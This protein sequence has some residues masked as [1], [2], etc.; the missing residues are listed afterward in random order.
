[1]YARTAGLCVL[2]SLGL[3]WAQDVGESA[4]GSLAPVIASIQ[5]SQGYPLSYAE[6]KG[7]SV[8]EWRRRGRREVQ[9]RLAFSPKP[10]PLDLKT[11]STERRDGYELHSISFAGSEHYRVPAFLLVPTLGKAP[12]P[13]LVALHDHGGYFYHGKEKIVESIPEHP[14]LVAFRKQSYGGRA[15]A[16]EF[17]RRGFVVLVIDAFYWGE[18]RLQYKQAPPDYQ[19]LIAGLEPDNAEYVSAVNGYL[20]QRT[21]ELNTWMNHSG[22]NWLGIINHDDR[23]SVD[24]LSSLPQVRKDRIGCVGLSV[25]ALRAT[26][27]ARMDSRIRAA[28]IVGW[29]TSLASILE[30]PYP[31]H[32]NL[33]AAFGLHTSLDHPDVAS[34][35]APACA[36]FVQQCRRDRLFTRAGMEAAAEKIAAVYRNMG[37]LERYR[38]KFFDVPHQFN[39]EMQEEAFEWLRRWLESAR[40]VGE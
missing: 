13:A 31:A 8:E 12:Y 27:L 18:R 25:G 6:R 40:K 35:A 39:V 23:R 7:V 33:P 34:L 36:M 29:M 19:K 32:P 16:S 26:Y 30:L 9:H 14:A 38:W 28:L 5:K 2:S 11:H 1:M 15:Y 10:I 21:A 4:L 17:A 22:A 20:S 3:A 37:G 24:L